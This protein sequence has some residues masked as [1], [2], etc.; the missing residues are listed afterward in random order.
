MQNIRLVYCPAHQGIEENELADSVAK[1]VSKKARHLQPST[2]ISSSEKQQSNKMLPLSK[3][4]RRWGHSKHTKYK[5]IVPSIAHMK[6]ILRATCLKNISRKGISKTARLKTG[7]SLLKGHKSKTDTEFSP[8]CSTCKV[9]ET[10]KHFLLNC[11]EYDKERAKLE[12][13]VKKIFCKSNCHKL[14]IIIDDLL[15]ESDL[16]SQDAAI[17]RKKVGEFILA[18]GK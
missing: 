8:E 7:H 14:D 13:Y 15:V 11:K 1:T 9:K 3:W 17:V 5:D 10:H 12:K 18:T 4:A 16:P 2:Q 6:L